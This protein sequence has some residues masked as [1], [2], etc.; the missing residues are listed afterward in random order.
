MAPFVPAARQPKARLQCCFACR[1]VGLPLGRGTARKCS[2]P[3][4]SFSWQGLLECKPTFGALAVPPGAPFALRRAASLNRDRGRGRP[5]GPLRGRRYPSIRR[6]LFSLARGQCSSTSS[7]TWTQSEGVPGRLA[8]RHPSI[9]AKPSAADSYRG[10]LQG[11]RASP[12]SFAAT[13]GG[14]LLPSRPGRAAPLA[15]PPRR[16]GA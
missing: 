9:H 4:K 16:G 7:S 13:V 12:G 8:R 2:L 3:R 10:H 5:S 14:T 15:F 11:G 6:R 1:R